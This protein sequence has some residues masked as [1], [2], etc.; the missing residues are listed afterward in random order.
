MTASLIDS[1]GWTLLHFTW[2]GLLIGCTSAAVLA[3]MRN[4]R[5]EYRY[6]VACVALLACVLWPAAELTL[7]LQDANASA[8][9]L[10]FADQ[11]MAG[12]RADDAS[13]AGWL[14]EQLLWIVG[15]WSVCAA[16]LALRMAAGLAWIRH[17]SQAPLAGAEWQARAGRMASAFGITRAVRVRVVE[18]LDSPLTIGWLRPVVLVP[19]SLMTGMPPELLEALLAH[20]MA[21]VRR[22]DYLV[23][24]GQN[25]VEILLFYHP[26]VWWI[27]G[28][29]RTE[30]EQIADDLAARHLGEPRRLAHALSELE[31]LQFSSHHLAI[32]ANGGELVT[33]VRRL[34]KP[35]RQALDWKASLP[36]LGLAAACFSLYAH[37]AN[38]RAAVTPALAKV[39]P[40]V[41][42]AS[43]AKPVWPAAS[44]KAEHTGTVTLAF[45]VGD[46]GRVTASRIAASS[47]HALLD[48]AAR[49]GIMKCQFKPGT[50]NGKPV[51]AWMNMK[52]VWML[53]GG[54]D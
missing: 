36:A 52:Y 2:Q 35:G 50:E 34:V 19:A 39:A 10:R 33:R 51:A 45:K 31:R 4:T 11:M 18:N 21:H 14:Q 30:R 17:A 38:D 49:A 28:R 53:K 13:L 26:A 27:S 54:D 41:D 32:A 24:L 25:V 40:V 48:E 43:C 22:F 23:N 46:T 8:A 1:I 7:R 6:N 16:L 3:L 42:F 47:G 5:P 37:A 29:I 20:E 9:H 44:F 12:A 15:F